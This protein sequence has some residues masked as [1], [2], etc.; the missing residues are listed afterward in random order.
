MRI[1]RSPDGNIDPIDRELAALRIFKETVVEMQQEV[2][3]QTKL[4][5]DMLSE[6]GQKSIQREGYRYTIQQAERTVI[7]ENGLRKALGARLFNKMTI[8]KLDKAKLDELIQQ[9]EVDPVVVSQYAEIQLNKPAVRVSEL[10]L[11]QAHE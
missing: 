6:R 9:G 8:R 3:E 4:V 1:V 5:V 11:E 7:N 2:E 10:S